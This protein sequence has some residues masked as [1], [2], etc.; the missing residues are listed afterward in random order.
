MIP[1]QWSPIKVGY[2]KDAA[3]RIAHWG[4]RR[5]LWYRSQINKFSP[6]DVYLTLRILSVVSVQ[7]EKLHGYGY[8]KEIVVRRADRKLYKLKEG[9]FLNL[10]LH[11]IE[12]MLLLQVQHKLFNLEGS[13]IIDL[14]VAQRMFTRRIIIRKRVEDVQ[15]EPYTPSFDQPG[16]FYE[17]SSNQKRLMQADELYKFSDGTLTL[18]QDKLYYRVLNFRMG[19]NKG[20]P[21]R[22]WSSTDQRQSNIIVDM[23]NKLL[24]ERRLMRN[25]ERLN[26]RDLPMG[27][28][29]DRIEVLRYDTKGVK[30]RIGRMQTKTELTLE[31]TQQGVSD[32]VLSDTKVFTMTMEILPEPTSNKLCGRFPD[33]NNIQ[34]MTSQIHC[35]ML[36]LDQQISIQDKAFQ[37]R[38]SFQDKEMYE[39]IGQE[40][41]SSQEGKRS[42]DDEE[43]MFG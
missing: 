11:D 35:H 18:V 25:L 1:N 15:L 9:D 41:T 3:F 39:H 24:W 7:V 6:H 43:I 34:S 30:V 27:I 29:L 4:Y 8:L 10:H 31:Q 37:R 26:Q 19:Y 17:D 21:R 20:M 14:A 12:D 38:Q 22:K 33:G 28:P 5:K 13:D 16:V 2:N 32:E 40:V 36:I 23:I 42:Q